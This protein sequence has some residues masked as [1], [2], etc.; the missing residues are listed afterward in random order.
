MVKGRDISNVIRKFF[1]GFRR[2]IYRDVYADYLFRLNWGGKNNLRK[3]C[4]IPI[5]KKEIFSCIPCFSETYPETLVS[6]TDSRFSIFMA[7]TNRT[8]KRANSLHTQE[9]HEIEYKIYIL[10]SILLR[11]YA[12]R[13]FTFVTVAPYHFCF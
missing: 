10:F 13:L 8:K 6:I 5:K 2:I 1:Q 3:I 9:L 11:V 4:Y 7:F 12:F